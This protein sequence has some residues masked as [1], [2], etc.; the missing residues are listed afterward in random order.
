MIEITIHRKKNQY[1]GF[2]S[3]GHAEYAEEGYDIICAAVSVLTVNTINSIEAFTADHFAV[4][5]GD[6]LVELILEGTVSKE[7]ALL[8]DS[9]VLGLQDIQKTYGKEYM[10]IT[11]EEV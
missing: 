4:R 3:E 5:Q 7:T 6:G 10:T 8:M 11:F 2:I 9:M 1:A